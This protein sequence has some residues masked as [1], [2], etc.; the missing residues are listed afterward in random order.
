MFNKLRYKYQ[1]YRSILREIKNWPSY[2]LFKLGIHP[3]DK[4]EFKFKDGHS[5][6]VPKKMIGPFRECFFDDQYLQKFNTNDF[7]SSPVIIDIGANVGYAALYFFRTFPEATIHSFEP[8]PFL[9]SV[10]HQ[11]QHVHKNYNWKIHPYGLWKESGTLELFTTSTDDFTAISGV[12]KLPDADK[13]IKIQVST[14]G[15]FIKDND[16]KMIDLLKLDCE[17][18]EYE[19]LFSLSDADYNKVNK[20]AMETHAT[21]HHKTEDLVELLKTKGFQLS[22]IT[23]PETGH[24]WA[25]R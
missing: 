23:K 13:K 4:F 14:L 16:I 9:Q 11:N 15:H 22:Y 5:Y 21:A 6:V 20:I 25:W 19:I 8:M 17:G 7:P 18:A 2:F 24:I 1:R 3:G 12:I 10:L